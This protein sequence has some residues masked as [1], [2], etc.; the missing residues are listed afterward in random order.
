[1]AYRMRIRAPDFANLQA[2]PLMAKG[3]LLSDFI[4]IIGSLDYILPDTDR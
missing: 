3:Y 2:M 1:M 4:A